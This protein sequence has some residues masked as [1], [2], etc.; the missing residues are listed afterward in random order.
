[1]DVASL[2]GHDV[3][4]VDGSTEEV[5]LIVY[6]TGYR[7]E[8]PFLAETLGTAGSSPGL[9]AHALVPGHPTLFVAGH[10][11][12]DGGAYPLFCRQAELFAALARN[13]SARDRLAER[14]RTAPPDLTGG[15][16]HIDSARHD[17][18]VN[19]EAYNKFLVRLVRGS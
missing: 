9:W 5:D 1:V 14:M 4:F 13:A 12:S 8:I 2:E 18:H 17:I 16:R 7:R 10:F 15:I 3:R 19:T 6:A 11:D